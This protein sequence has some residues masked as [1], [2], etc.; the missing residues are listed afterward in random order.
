MTSPTRDNNEGV[1]KEMMSR[2]RQQLHE[3]DSELL[4]LTAKY[5]RVVEQLE[6]LRQAIERN[7][8]AAVLT[9]PL[10]PFPESPFAANRRLQ[11]VA[12][13]EIRR[14]QLSNS[15]ANRKVTGNKRKAVDSIACSA[16]TW[17]WVEGGYEDR[18]CLD[19]DAFPCHGFELSDIAATVEALKSQ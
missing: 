2:F 14:E 16:I 10:E 6:K 8:T 19:N 9:L 18:I 3:N 15:T 13:L 1:L 4:Q 7:K 12:L 17:T 5:D 11:S